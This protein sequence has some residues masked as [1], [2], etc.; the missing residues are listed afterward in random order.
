MCVHT[1][2]WIKLAFERADWDSFTAYACSVAESSG[3][4]ISLEDWATIA[5]PVDSGVDGNPAQQAAPDDGADILI[6]A[7]GFVS[8]ACAAAEVATA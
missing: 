6:D 4:G 3:E 8:A 2:F 1:S 5:A 7:W